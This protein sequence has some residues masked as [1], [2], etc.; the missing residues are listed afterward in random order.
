M[1]TT[2]GQQG[3]GKQH[4]QATFTNNCDIYIFS[5]TLHLNLDWIGGVLQQV[6]GRDHLDQ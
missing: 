3:T 2:I 6:S 1:K 4:G 5:V